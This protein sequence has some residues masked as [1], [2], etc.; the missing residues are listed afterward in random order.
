[1]TDATVTLTSLGD[2]G[3]EK[4]YGVI[5][6]P[7]VALVGFGKIS[8]GV[9]VDNGMIGVRPILHATIAGDHRATDGRTG[10][11]F[12]DIL[13]KLLRLPEKLWE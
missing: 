6:P 7:Q 10:A 11:E 4:V 13:D 2:M 3:V 9:W 5:Y 12:L 1:M 8:D